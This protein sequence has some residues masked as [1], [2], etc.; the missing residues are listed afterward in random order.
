M[1]V[2]LV[3][4]PVDNDNNVL[5]ELIGNTEAEG[6]AIKNRFHLLHKYRFPG[7]AGSSPD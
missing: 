5:H 3:Q 2:G 1:R 7:L 4:S 6:E